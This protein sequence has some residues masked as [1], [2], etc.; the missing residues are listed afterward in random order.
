[1][2]ILIS[3]ID[4]II[5][6]GYHYYSNENKVFKAFG[7]NDREAIEILNHYFTKIIFITADKLG[8]EIT[9]KRV[10]IDMQQTLLYVNSKDRKEYLSSFNEPIWFLGDGIK[11]AQC[12]IKVDFFITVQNATSYSKEVADLILP[13]IGGSN[14]LS[15]LAFKI[16]RNVIR[17]P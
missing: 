11:D 14:V 7:S 13:T 3:D 4:G 2:A 17:R 15:E 12:Q 10:E 8:F 1:M 9:K 16:E 6:N 5:T